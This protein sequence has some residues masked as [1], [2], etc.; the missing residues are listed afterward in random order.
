MYIFY[1]TSN[2]FSRG[3][4]ISV[5]K[6]S[7]DCS[8]DFSNAEITTCQTDLMDNFTE[9][10]PK[11]SS[12]LN[13]QQPKKAVGMTSVAVQTDDVFIMQSIEPVCCLLRCGEPDI[14]KDNGCGRT[15]FCNETQS[16]KHLENSAVDL[17]DFLAKASEKSCNGFCSQKGGDFSV[18]K[19]CHETNCL[20]LDR[21]EVRKSLASQLVDKIL[22]HST[23]DECRQIAVL[24][25]IVHKFE[26]NQL[27]Q[28][29]VLTFRKT[30]ASESGNGGSE[31][32]L[33]N[34]DMS[35]AL[36]QTSKSSEQPLNGFQNK[37][38]SM[39]S[40]A[41]Q[42]VQKECST[43]NNLGSPKKAFM[44]LAPEIVDLMIAES[45][46]RF[47]VKQL[48]SLH[49]LS[50]TSVS[51]LSSTG[52]R[53]IDSLDIEVSVGTDCEKYSINENRDSVCCA[54][55]Y[56]SYEQNTNSVATAL[57]IGSSNVSGIE[58]IPDEP[59]EQVQNIASG[60]CCNPS[61]F[62]LSKICGTEIDTD[63]TLS[64]DQD[65][66]DA[67][68]KLRKRQSKIPRKIHAVKQRPSY[69][70]GPRMSVSKRK[71]L[72]IA[73]G[74]RKSLLR[75]RLTA[76]KKSSFPTVVSFIFSS[77]MSLLM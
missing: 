23:P 74:G 55:S 1:T 15:V 9:T 33:L 41:E 56:D 71:S 42:R 49:R 28:S 7:P 67:T 24:Q 6:S 61:S 25:T 11:S 43:E 35:E 46:T 20:I 5:K 22:P 73:S 44:S 37:A 13:Q 60:V 53:S 52:S 2:L 58:A 18:E 64:D 72:L 48:T 47:P 65:V 54:V 17:I 29:I 26:H 34:G 8:H 30:M 69:V 75:S 19:F 27:L 57:T 21:N 66:K 51:S 62:S 16:A 32:A 31:T 12:W 45:G 38:Q 77:F 3:S 36:Q 70:I 76:A 40:A 14:C 68:K 10:T 4:Y 50:S 63:D 59:T 39:N